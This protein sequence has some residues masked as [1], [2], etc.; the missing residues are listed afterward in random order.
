MANL[1]DIRR[2]IRSVR[3][4]A[5]ITRAM[6]MVAASKMRKAQEAAVFGRPYA[7]LL[8]QMLTDVN[9]VTGRRR[10]PLMAT[11]DVRLTAVVV[12]STDKG[13]CGGMNA[14]LLREVLT[15]DPATTVFVAVGRKAAQFI[16]RARRRLIGEFTWRETYLLGMA[17]MVARFVAGLF[18]DGDIDRVELLFTEFFSTLRQEPRRRPFLPVS[19]VA[20]LVAEVGHGADRDGGAVTGTQGAATDLGGCPGFLFEPSVG[21][22]LQPLLVTALDFQMYQVFLESRAS[23]NSARMVAMRNATENAADLAATLTLDYNK[24]RQAAITGELVEISAAMAAG[25]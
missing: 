1:R 19:E 21:D 5:Q 16:V 12:V 8:A 9:A 14:V 15:Y 4:T 20:R 24:L 18:L 2:R 10:H 13:L 23:E 17:R 11:R 3:N 7:G 22:L 25:S 6:Q